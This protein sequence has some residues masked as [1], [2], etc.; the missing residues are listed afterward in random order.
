M[1]EIK[2]T[3][4]AYTNHVSSL[5]RTMALEQPRGL[6]AYSALNMIGLACLSGTFMHS[7]T[8]AT[9]IMAPMIQN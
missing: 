5:P 1:Q 3:I 7:I 8:Q 9:V 2:T 4:G 6:T